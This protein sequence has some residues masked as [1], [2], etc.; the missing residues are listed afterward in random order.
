MKISDGTAVQ[1]DYTL[2]NDAGEVLD[3]SEGRGPLAYLHGAGNIIPGLEAAL[4]GKGAGDTLSVSI[5]PAEGYGE[6]D[7]AM[8]MTVALSQLP[9][10][11]LA[12]VGAHLNVQT[13]QGIRL[14]TVTAVTGSR[15][16]LDLNHPLAGETLHFDVHV[17][18]I[19]EASAEER[20][21]GHVH[22]HGGHAH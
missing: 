8:V 12:Q 3:T 10:R 19:Q 17:V 13:G 22:A 18:D 16:T 5:P 11:K 7:E 6:R 9:D 2:R 14:A 15:V 21:H 4:E 1:I 20:A